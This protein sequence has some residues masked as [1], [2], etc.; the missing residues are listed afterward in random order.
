M[1][2]SAFCDDAVTLCRSAITKKPRMAWIE[3]QIEVTHC[4]SLNKSAIHQ[5]LYNRPSALH[6]YGIHSLFKT[7]I[8]NYQ[9]P[10]EVVPFFINLS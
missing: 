8:S 9:T 7:I 5:V 1:F 2:L 3:L 6:R 4:L 10:S